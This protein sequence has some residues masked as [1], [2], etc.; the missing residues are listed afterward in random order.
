MHQKKER[1][2][3]TDAERS[4]EDKRTTAI[5]FFVLL[6][7]MFVGLFL[8]AYIAEKIWTSLGYEILLN[9]GR[10]FIL[11]ITGF[12]LFG[13]GKAILRKIWIGNI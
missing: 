10:L 6:P 5:A 11:V 8:T 12:M 4:N 7:L 3:M 1:W 9:L 13:I 2:E